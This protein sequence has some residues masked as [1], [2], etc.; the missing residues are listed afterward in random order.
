MW[1]LLFQ[2]RGTAFLISLPVGCLIGLIYDFFRLIRVVYTGGRIKLFFEDVLFCI[3]SSLVFTV[4]MFNVNMGVVRLFAVFGALVGFF[5]YRF[6]VGIFTV[7]L[8]KKLK[9]LMTAPIKRAVGAFSGRLVL[10]HTRRVTYADIKKV[11]R[12]AK[13]GF[14]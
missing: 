1:L 10:Y 2:D 7:P 6:S 14:C 4:F 9:A 8:A 12:L 5:A 13:N 11:K 3:M